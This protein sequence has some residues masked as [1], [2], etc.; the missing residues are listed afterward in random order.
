MIL[1]TSY[2]NQPQVTRII[3]IGHFVTCSSEVGNHWSE[4][5]QFVLPFLSGLALGSLHS[6]KVL[7][8]GEQQVPSCRF[9]VNSLHFPFSSVL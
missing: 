8:L 7:C 1:L 6:C 4:C 9:T 5:L 2:V 3:L